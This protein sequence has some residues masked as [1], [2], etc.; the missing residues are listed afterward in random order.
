MRELAQELAATE[1]AVEEALAQAARLMRRTVEVRRGLGLTYGLGEPA[2]RRPEAV[3]ARL[4]ASL[5]LC[6]ADEPVTAVELAERFRIERVPRAPWSL[7]EADL[8][9]DA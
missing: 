6:A 9:H 3:L 1:A 4:G 2:M 5:D 8:C 7:T